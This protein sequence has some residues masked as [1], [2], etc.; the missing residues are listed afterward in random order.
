MSTLWLGLGI[1]GGIVLTIV[2]CVELDACVSRHAQNRHDLNMELERKH[3]EEEIQRQ[4]AETEKQA[5]QYQDVNTLH[6]GSMV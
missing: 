3:K 6:N 1:T 4:E 5:T 2:F